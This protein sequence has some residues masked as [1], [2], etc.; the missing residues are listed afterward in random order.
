MDTS[1]LR[2]IYRAFTV[3]VREVPGTAVNALYITLKTDVSI[4][5]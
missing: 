5:T 4:V 1:V 2:V 3:G